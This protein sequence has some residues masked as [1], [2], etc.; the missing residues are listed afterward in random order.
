MRQR[1]SDAQLDLLRILRKQIKRAGLAGSKI[2]AEDQALMM[3]GVRRGKA[4]VKINLQ[5][6]GAARSPSA[7]RAM[8]VLALERELADCCSALERRGVLLSAALNEIEEN[9]AHTADAERA[10][11]ANLEEAELM[12]RAL[13]AGMAGV[14]RIAKGMLPDLGGELDAELGRRMLMNSTIGMPRVQMMMNTM[15][16]GKSA[17]MPMHMLSLGL[18]NMGVLSAAQ[19]GFAGKRFAGRRKTADHEYMSGTMTHGT[20]AAESRQAGKWMD[21]GRKAND[22]K[23]PQEAAV[24]EA[25]AL[26]LLGQNEDEWYMSAEL[27]GRIAGALQAVMETGMQTG[28]EETERELAGA[29]MAAGCTCITAAAKYPNFVSFERLSGLVH[30]AFVS[31]FCEYAI[32]MKKKRKSLEESEGEISEGFEESEGELSE[33]LEAFEGEMSEAASMELEE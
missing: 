17:Y 8:L 10:A 9:G 14:R 23:S 22:R 12:E 27:T 30:E 32:G 26:Y 11:L 3:S 33:G 13:G 16:Y 7:Y 20:S 29:V 1:L 25:A 19:F 15:A 4:E 28:D 6:L 31:I 21:A 24:C 5:A 18:M 2:R